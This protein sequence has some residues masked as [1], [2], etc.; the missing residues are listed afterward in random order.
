MI[1]NT[2]DSIDM[3]P[4]RVSYRKNVLFG[5]VKCQFSKFGSSK[6]KRNKSTLENWDKK[7]G[8]RR[9]VGAQGEL[10]K[11]RNKCEV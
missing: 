7:L 2:A 9:I 3:S 11:L 6:A 8:H 10:R 5:Q 4:T 1:V